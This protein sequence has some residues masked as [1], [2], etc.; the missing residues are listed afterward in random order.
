MNNRF[1]L[2]ADCLLLGL[3]TALAAIP[4][5]TAYPA[6]VAACTMLRDQ[7]PVGPRTYLRCLQSVLR[8]DFLIW[9]VP[10]TAVAV[11]TADAIAVGAGVPGAKPMAALLTVAIAATA[12]V[13]LRS[14]AAWQPARRWRSLV[15]AAARDAARDLGGSALLLFAIISAA[16]IIVF[17]PITA[18]LVTGP[19][20][21]AA[22]AVSSRSRSRFHDATA[23]R[24]PSA[25]LSTS[26]PLSPAPPTSPPLA[27][28]PPTSPQ[29]SPAPPTPPPIATAPHPAA[30]LTSAGVAAASAAVERSGNV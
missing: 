7:T 9:W 18:L 25:A 19:L 26:P 8:S 20:A 3:F 14:A 5:V 15:P 22:V 6:F 29:L 1:A 24:S 12:V 30:P 27:T 11:A 13:A 28:A 4:M 10:S 23:A 16:A 21:L 17:V 2:F